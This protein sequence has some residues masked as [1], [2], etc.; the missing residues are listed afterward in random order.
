MLEHTFIHLPDFGPRRERR[1]WESGI[2]T[3]YDFLERFAHSQ[4]HKS[5]CRKI[6]SSVYALKLG[7]S[8]FFAHSLQ[9][10]ETWRSFPHFKK[11]AYLDI[12][13]T[14]LAPETDYVTVI[15]I[16]DGSRAYSYVHGD[17]LHQFLKDITRYDAVVTF[18]GSLFDIPFLKKS[19]ANAKI[20]KLHID[21][22]F[23]LQSL[24]VRGGLKKIEER[25]GYERED[26]LK[27]MTGYDA[28]KLWQA[29]LR[30][31]DRDALD[32]LV[33]Y[34]SADIGNLKKLME[35]S[36]REKRMRTGF[37]EIKEGLEKEN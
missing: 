17:N 36:Y 2:E 18:N 5:L 15:G 7:D 22:R 23:V 26:D 35:W 14:G 29:Y 28:V 9:S 16:F 20:P 1:L 3:W 8:D 12:E 32:K 10:G 11:I 13:T 19:F 30:R 37:D 4:H 25:F 33:R 24:G 6:A 21:L 31:K 27:G 34:N